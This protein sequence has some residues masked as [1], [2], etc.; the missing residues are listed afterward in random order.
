MAPSSD[1][2]VDYPEDAM[3]GRFM[4][5]RQLMTSLQVVMLAL[6]LAA[7]A[8]QSSQS[9][10][11]DSTSTASAAGT[12]AGGTATGGEPLPA[13]ID[14]S[15]DA[16]PL[17]MRFDKGATF[18]YAI[19]IVQRVTL[20]RDTMVEKNT[21][22]IRYRYRFRVLEALPD[23]SGRLEATCIAVSFRG[24]YGGA[25]T[26]RTLEY[27]S[28]QKNDGAKEKLFAQY[29]APLN[30]PFTMIVSP[31]G[32]ITKVENVDAILRR[33]M[34]ADYATTKMETK[35]R[36]ERDLADQTL[37]GIVQMA[38]QKFEQRAIAPDSSWTVT[39]DERLGYLSIRNHAAY[40]LRGFTREQGG[41]RAHIDIHITSKYTGDKKVDTGQ[42]MATLDEFTVDGRGRTVY[43]MTAGNPLKRSFT[44]RMRVKFY[45]QPPEELK[46]LAP[47]QA[48]DFWMTQDAT[49]ENSI[50]R[51]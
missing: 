49:V 29:N 20:T 3:V 4:H 46:Q 9:Q 10:A 6:V 7:C 13:D 19:G 17:R 30:T 12:A 25:G 47:E 26:A 32:T 48:K 1:G 15:T 2:V 35:Q 31:L 27:D 42:G 22:D 39:Q 11:A 28:E 33:L 8:K 37:K 24:E 44:Q 51:F 5:G 14:R 23:G 40:T 21:Q 18:G 16:V 43:D 34:G 50:E 38:F 45:V 41:E 36:L